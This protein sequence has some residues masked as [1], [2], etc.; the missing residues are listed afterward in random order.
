MR[1]PFPSRKPLRSLEP[2]P[3][4]KSL[5]RKVHRPA[6]VAFCPRKMISPNTGIRILLTISVQFLKVVETGLDIGANNIDV[7]F[8]RRSSPVCFHSVRS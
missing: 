5:P 4:Q 3:G 8:M 2:L 6:A 7:Q 1:P